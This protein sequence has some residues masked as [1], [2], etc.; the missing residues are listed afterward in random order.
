MLLR[1]Y[2]HPRFYQLF[3]GKYRI[4]I[5]FAIYQPI[6]LLDEHVRPRTG[7]LVVNQTE[8]P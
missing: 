6:L 5:R 1:Q 2:F 8:R 4:R 3:H 7:Y